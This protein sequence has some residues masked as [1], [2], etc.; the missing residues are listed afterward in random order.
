MR[1]AVCGRGLR[2]SRQHRASPGLGQPSAHSKQHAENEH[3]QCIS[4]PR[5]PSETFVEPKTV[6]YI[7]GQCLT[8][9][10]ERAGGWGL[11]GDPVPWRGLGGPSAKLLHVGLLV[12][13]VPGRGLCPGPLAPATQVH[14][15]A[16]EDHSWG[17]EHSPVSP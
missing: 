7:L 4:E 9:R 13:A 15:W 14:V 5:V 2:I 12:L 11:A 1:I 8:P 17:A 16:Q 6:L 10:H 3:E